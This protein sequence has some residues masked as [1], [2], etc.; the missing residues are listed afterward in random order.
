[1]TAH[2]HAYPVKGIDYGSGA[3]QVEV[4]NAITSDYT[5]VAHS[6]TGNTFTIHRDDAGR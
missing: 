2:A 3:C 1:M 5:V 6:R 4:A